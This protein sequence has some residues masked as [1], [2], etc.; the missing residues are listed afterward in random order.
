MEEIRKIISE[1]IIY[2]VEI[3]LGDRYYSKKNA[4]K[5]AVFI[6]QQIE[7]V[8]RAINKSIKYRIGIE[9]S[10]NVDKKV[11]TESTTCWFSH[12]DWSINVHFKNKHLSCLLLVNNLQLLNN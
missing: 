2:N 5:W 7:N 3:M 6:V 9:I 1:S 12:K 10:E 8:I 4:D 11:K